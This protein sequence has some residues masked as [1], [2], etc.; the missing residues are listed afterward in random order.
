MELVRVGDK[1]ISVEKIHNMVEEILQARSRGLSQSEAAAQL[2]ID[3]AF[4]SRLETLGEVRRGR[5]IALIGFPVANKTPILELCH[6]L[7]VDFSFVM[8]D[9][10][11]RAFAESRSGIELV[12]EIFRLARD[13][14]R[15]DT[16]ILMAS[17]MR[18]R[19]LTTLL[20]V[21]SVIPMVLGDT[22]LN[23]DVEVD[24]PVLESIIKEVQGQAGEAG[25]VSNEDS[26]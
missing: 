7:G 16:V 18:V 8:T 6:R 26:V 11:R 12:N 20:D 9:Q 13:V 25:P 21:H 23:R 2:G 4:V 10:E 14:R 5:S 17:N 15:F 19:L 22:P 24:I 1:L 3:R